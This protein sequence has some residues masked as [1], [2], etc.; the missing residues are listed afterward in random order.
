MR[1]EVLFPRWF[2]DRLAG[3]ATKPCPEHHHVPTTHLKDCC[4]HQTI[5]V[6]YTK[7]QPI[8]GFCFGQEPVSK[9]NH[10]QG[11]VFITVTHEICPQH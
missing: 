11:D 8:P 7:I 9:Q 6:T 10:P 5:S 1:K 3:T 2:N 4:P